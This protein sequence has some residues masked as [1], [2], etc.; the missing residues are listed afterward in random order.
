MSAK[1]HQHVTKEPIQSES[2]HD[3]HSHSHELQLHDLH[4]KKTKWVVIL[5][6]ITMMIEIGA[7]YLSHSMALL[8]DGWHMSSHVLALGLTWIA[9]RVIKNWKKKGQQTGE[10]N[11]V[12]SL[13]GYTSAVILAV[14]GGM[15]L[16]ES[17]ER[18]I[19]PEVVIYG[20]AMLVAGI[21]L[22][23]NSIS[24]FIL[25]H[26]HHHG[27]H[28]IR[29]AY[30]HVLADTLTSVLAIVALFLGKTFQIAWMD[31]VAGIVGAL[32]VLNWA[33]SLLKSSAKDLLNY[34]SKQ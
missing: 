12:L 14:V 19:N 8:A 29:A 23:V 15:V 28:N 2:S 30:M 32:V 17:L 10:H 3:H 1:N 21:G 26:D 7:G 13:S 5:S 33:I 20:E 16:I 22:I 9:Y 4:E 25:H 27:D 34:K 6:S 31:A 11:K 18:L 24:T